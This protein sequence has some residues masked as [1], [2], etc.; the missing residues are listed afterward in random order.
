MLSKNT[1][2]VMRGAALWAAT[3]ASVVTVAT[4]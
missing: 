3:F 2:S 1:V 4:I